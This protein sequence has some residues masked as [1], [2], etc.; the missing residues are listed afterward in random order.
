[1]KLA[2]KIA[3][4]KI[5]IDS[6][7]DTYLLNTTKDYSC[8]CDSFDLYIKAIVT[9]KE[10]PVSDG[11]KLTDRTIGNW[12]INDDG[13]Y[14]FFYFDKYN[15]AY[16]MRIAFNMQ[17]KNIQITLLDVQ[18]KF[19]VDSQYFLFNAVGIAFTFA[20]TFF[21]GFSVHASSIVYNNTGLAFSALSGT[22]KSTHTGLWL[23]NYPGTVILNDDK[24]AMRFVDG[25][26]KIY[27]TPWAGT[28]G[29]NQNMSVPLKALV[30]LERSEN[31]TIRDCIGPEAIKRFFEAIV[32]P[33]SDETTNLLLDSLSLLI[34]H[35]RICVLGCNMTDEA[36]ETVRKYLY[37]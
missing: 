12:Y 7:Y 28:T 16:V 26:W 27:G 13:V 24:P 30:F 2:L 18:K 31:N 25:E 11:K 14:E 37:D 23:K 8:K 9:Q 20:M 5:S 19:S 10:L 29:I 36:P 32:H 17:E 3:D 6:Y 33:V 15:N 1:M 22:G 35:S 34:K 4:L 21:N